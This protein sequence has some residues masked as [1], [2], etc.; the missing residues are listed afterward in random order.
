MNFFKNL[1][2]PKFQQYNEFIDSFD[3]IRGN[4]VAIID[5]KNLAY[6]KSFDFYIKSQRHN[7]EQLENIKKISNDEIRSMR[8]LF[9]SVS[10]SSKD[11]EELRVLNENLQKT[12]SALTTAVNELNKAK[13]NHARAE[14]NLAKARAKNLPTQIQTWENNT[15]IANQ[16]V[17]AAE[18]AVQLAK[19]RLGSTQTD[20]SKEFIAKLSETLDKLCEQKMT[21]L[22]ELIPIA[23]A[24][25][26]AGNE[27]NDFEDGAIKRLEEKLEQL[28]KEVI[29]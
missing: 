3:N 16:N 5:G 2:R 21:E 23:E 6:E 29:E 11:F 17:Q 19:E 8:H 7:N 25:E 14:D 4:G 12:Q 1:F 26:T 22:D 10:A 24:L 13:A 27:I 20:Y 9:S 18:R 28:E 15:N